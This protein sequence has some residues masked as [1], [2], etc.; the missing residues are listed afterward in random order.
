MTNDFKNYLGQIPEDFELLIKAMGN[1][2]RFKLILLLLEK[3][4]LSFS[5]IANQL[6]RKNSLILNHLK[7][8]EIAGIVQNYLQRNKNTKEF[9]FYELTKYGYK[10]IND[11]IKS[12][13]SYFSKFQDESKERRIEYQK[14]I[15]RDFELT[16]KALSNKYRFALSLY[17]IDEGDLSFSEIVL[18]LKKN[19]SSISSHLTKLELGG[20][21]QNYLEKKDISNNYSFYQITNYGKKFVLDLIN[22]YNDYYKGFSEVKE[23]DYDELTEKLST[24]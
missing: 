13:N 6:N 15:P 23:K 4:K 18:N 17:L 1:I 2:F 12:Y 8:L 20:I 14:E 19:K 7:K 3:E 24:I 16:L 22:S 11:L 5:K 21:I 9:S 10:I